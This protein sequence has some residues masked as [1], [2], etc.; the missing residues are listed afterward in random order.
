MLDAMGTVP[1]RSTAVA[2]ADRIIDRRTAHHDPD[3]GATLPAP[4]ELAALLGWLTRHTRAAA[5]PKDRA[6]VLVEDVAD[7]WTILRHLVADL[8]RQRRHLDKL[9][10]A[11]LADV[12]RGPA[13]LSLAGL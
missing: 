2:A 10:L 7:G 5:D 12:A 6:A 11:L 8:D 13:G 9:A 3:L 1:T 4:D